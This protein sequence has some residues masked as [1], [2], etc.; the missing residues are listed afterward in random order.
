MREDI[1]ASIP[2]SLQKELEILETSGYAEQVDINAWPFTN[3]PENCWCGH[4]HLNSDSQACNHC[5]CV[6]FVL[7]KWVT[8]NG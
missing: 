8:S 3:E 5:Q 4:L 1:E 6:G 7:D 2:E